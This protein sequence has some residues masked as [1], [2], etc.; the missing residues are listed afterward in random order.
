MKDR[1]GQEEAQHHERPPFCV[2]KT[3]NPNFQFCNMLV[4][5]VLLAFAR[6]TDSNHVQPFTSLAFSVFHRLSEANLAKDNIAMS[7][8]SLGTALSLVLAGSEGETKKLLENK[9]GCDLNKCAAHALPS[10]GL[11][12]ANAVFFEKSLR[13]L[14]SFSHDIDDLFSAESLPVDFKLHSDAIRKEIDGCR[15]APM[16]GFRS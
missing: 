12:V 2:S 7:P 8:L 15:T 1:V 3:P 10:P 14:P 13:L 9:L 11:E 16:E 5:F 6:G 4:V